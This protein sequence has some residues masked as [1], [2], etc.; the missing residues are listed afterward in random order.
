VSPDPYATL[1]FAA[2]TGD[3]PA[4]V[5]ANLERASALLGVE[6][7]GFLSQ[8]HGTHA[9]RL[10]GREDPRELVRVEGDATF[11]TVEG[12]ACGVR[13]A[14]C[15]TILAGDRET[16]AVVAI[17]AGWRGTEL[18]VVEA[19]IAALREAIGSRG[20]IVAAI[21]PLIESCCF[22]VGADVA[23]RLASC[24]ALRERAIVK[25]VGEKAFVDLRAILEQKLSALGVET[26]Q[27]RG[28]TVCDRAR[29]FSYRREG[30]V[31]G[32]MLAAIVCLTPGARAD[33]PG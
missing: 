7:I 4:N 28:C 15:G 22:E 16:G 26:D 27:V 5:A 9:V 31:S 2:S 3:D 30:K 17:H 29:F 14:D 18:G 11:S 21:G 13:S 23:A 33:R 8:V 24:S 6:R 12:V 19:G 20:D 10:D 25:R 32:R 1:N